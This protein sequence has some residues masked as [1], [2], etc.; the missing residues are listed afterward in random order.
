MHLAG[1]LSK[2]VERRTDSFVF[3]NGLSLNQFA[4]AMWEVSNVCGVDSSVLSKVLNGKRL[5]TPYQLQVFCRTLRLT[6]GEREYLFYCLSKD[7]AL[8]SGVRLRAP[9][10]L[11]CATHECI[12]GLRHEMDVLFQAGKWKDVYDLSGIIEPYLHDYAAVLYNRDPE[13]TLIT[14]YQHVLYL[15]AKSAGGVQTQAAIMRETRIL[16]SKFRHYRNSAFAQLTDGYVYSFWANAYRILGLFPSPLNAAMNRRWTVLAGRSAAKALQLLPCTNSE[17]VFALRNVLD[18]AIM[19]GD[20]K[21]FLCH[22]KIAERILPQQTPDTFL[23]SMQLANTASKGMAVF[24]LDNPFVLKERM[25][26]HFG[27]DLAGARIHELSELKT[28]LEMYVALNVRKDF[29]VKQKIQRAYMLASEESE[30]YK[31]VI[32]W[33]AAQL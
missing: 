6:Q 9:F 2:Y 3:R 24:A 13:D 16:T 14:A 27:R 7:Q 8:K 33:L 32:D 26:R 17:Y 23:S 5:F 12:E 15:R 18:S 25:V 20:K 22:F 4:L 21:A 10:A 1:A 11:G 19:L 31:L 29:L 28:E 30:R